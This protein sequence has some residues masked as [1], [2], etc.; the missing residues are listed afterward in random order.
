MTIIGTNTTVGV[1]VNHVP[2]QEQ[3]YFVCVPSM[4]A[5]ELIKQQYFN[6]RQEIWVENWKNRLTELLHIVVRV[7]NEKFN[8]NEM[9]WTLN[10]YTDY[11]DLYKNSKMS[12]AKSLVFRE[13]IIF[14]WWWAGLFFGF[15]NYCS[16][17]VVRELL[18]GVSW[19]VLQV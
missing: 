13:N 16:K 10:Q 18:L 15:K 19:D 2:V 14:S 4:S 3:L 12:S 5:Q 1:F 7:P 9:N 8:I 11:P 17:T 6:S